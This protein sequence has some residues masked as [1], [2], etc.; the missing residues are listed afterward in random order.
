MKPNSHKLSDFSQGNIESQRADKQMRNIPYLMKKRK[1]E[2]MSSKGRDN[3]QKEDEETNK[4]PSK[5]ISL[6]LF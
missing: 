4:K 1:D 2:P 3:P 5:S 6:F